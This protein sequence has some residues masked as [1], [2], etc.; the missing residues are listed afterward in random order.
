[1]ST[2]RIPRGQTSDG[3]LVIPSEA[4]RGEGYCCPACNARIIL[5]KGPIVRA[6][7]AHR[8]EEGCS[9]ESV[10]HKTAKKLIVQ[11]ISNGSCPLIQLRC[12][13]CSNYFSVSFPRERVTGAVEE[14]PVGRYRVDVALFEKQEVVAAVEIR[15]SNRVSTQKG[16][17]LGIPWIELD[18]RAVV[19]NPL[20][21][22]ALEHRLR[23]PLCRECRKMEAHRRSE[24]TE[25]Y[26]REVSL[27]ARYPPHWIALTAYLSPEKRR[28]WLRGQF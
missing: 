4:L 16:A 15:N 24:K 14:H 28:K 20:V 5:R 19:R 7:F 27:R 6:H 11:V 17:T 2:F 21:W 18:A 23:T 8:A 26:R 3:R 22:N 1:M 10:L 13:G 12:H 25:L 9:L